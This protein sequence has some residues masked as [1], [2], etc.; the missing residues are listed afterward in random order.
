ML[1]NKTIFLKRIYNKFK[2]NELILCIF[3]RKKYRFWLLILLSFWG[4]AKHSMMEFPISLANQIM[5]PV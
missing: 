4:F 3:I 1:Q 2:I 5:S